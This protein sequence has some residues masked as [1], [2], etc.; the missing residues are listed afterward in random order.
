M[1]EIYTLDLAIV[2]IIPNALF[3]L[4]TIIMFVAFKKLLSEKPTNHYIWIVGG[5]ISFAGGIQ[6]AIWKI[7]IASTQNSIE[8]LSDYL[9]VYQSLGFALMTISASLN[10]YAVNHRERISIQPILFLFMA[11]SLRIPLL[12]LTVI[13]SGLAY[14]VLARLSF[15]HQCK[16]GAYFFIAA[17]VM[18]LAMGRLGAGDLTIMMQWIAEIVNIMAQIFFLIG[19]YQFNKFGCKI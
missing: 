16:G 1:A 18:F 14:F 13:F 12:A 6:K 11:A 7:L 19:A 9:F 2:D 3:L 8:V 4:S 17:F 5:L 15:K 10:L